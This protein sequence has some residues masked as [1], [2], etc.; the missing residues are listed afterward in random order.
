MSD[1]VIVAA[2]SSGGAVAAITALM[3]MFR[4]FGTLLPRLDVIGSDIKVFLESGE[5]K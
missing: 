3:L 2:I 4:L 1:S 5:R